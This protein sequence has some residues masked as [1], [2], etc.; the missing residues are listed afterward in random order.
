M[1]KQVVFELQQKPKYVFVYTCVLCI[2]SSQFFK[3]VFANIKK[4]TRFWK[5]AVFFFSQKMT[6][7][8]LILILGA[9][10]TGKVLLYSD[11]SESTGHGLA[12][13]L[14]SNFI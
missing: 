13:L 6:I 14:N 7:Y 8:V 2:Q 1:L 12:Q 10:S 4:K 11:L 5:Q 3:C 9:V